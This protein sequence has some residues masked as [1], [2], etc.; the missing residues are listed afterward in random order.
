VYLGYG[1][2][3]GRWEFAWLIFLTTP[4]Y[5]WG[6]KIVEDNLNRADSARTGEDLKAAGIIAL[7]IVATGLILA[8]VTLGDFLHLA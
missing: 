1:Y 2:I 4:F 5:Y 8:A 6:I 7:F 3:L